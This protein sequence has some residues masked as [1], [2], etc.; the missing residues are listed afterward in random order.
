MASDYQRIL[1]HLRERCMPRRVPLCWSMNL[2]H[3]FLP[4]RTLPFRLHI[5]RSH[6]SESSS[7]APILHLSC[8]LSMSYIKPGKSG[9]PI[10]PASVPVQYLPSTPSILL[11]GMSL[12]E[13]EFSSYSRS[14]SRFLEMLC[15]LLIHTCTF[16]AYAASSSIPDNHHFL[17][18]TASH[19]VVIPMTEPSKGRG[20]VPNF[21]LPAKAN[22]I[23]LL[24]FRSVGRIAAWST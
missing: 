8:E 23:Q 3:F 4:C 6:S 7:P 24:V 21:V 15:L 14:S 12:A 16:L 22:K 1:L 18:L 20:I 11:Y 2:P 13:L 9:I 10:R 19:F 5:Y 17:F